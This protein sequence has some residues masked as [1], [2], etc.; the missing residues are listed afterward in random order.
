MVRIIIL[1]L[2]VMGGAARGADLDPRFLDCSEFIRFINMRAE[3]ASAKVDYTQLYNSPEFAAYLLGEMGEIRADALLSAAKVE[4]S[5]PMEMIPHA[6][7]YAS[8]L[9]EQNV[10]DVSLPLDILVTTN[11]FNPANFAPSVFYVG[12]KTYTKIAKIG[13]GQ[14][15]AVFRVQNKESREI[16]VL[17]IGIPLAGSRPL[18]ESQSIIRQAGIPI[19][20]IQPLGP[21]AN[22]VEELPYF[23]SDVIRAAIKTGD[24][25]ELQPLISFYEKVIEGFP[26]YIHDLKLDN[27][28]RRPNGEWVITD[29]ILDPRRRDPDRIRA[30]EDIGKFFYSEF[31]TQYRKLSF[32]IFPARGDL[33]RANMRTIFSE[34]QLKLALD[35]YLLDAIPQD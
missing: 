33:I 35:D 23:G 24:T 2:F 28:G 9:V 20:D 7:V 31:L 1:I 14:E 3:P 19:L 12:D 29:W 13:A 22:F 30:T 15:H 4:N 6:R 17:K 18:T 11:K 10:W 25:S 34:I 8:V 5:T 16:R 21:H 26:I 27:V 32:E